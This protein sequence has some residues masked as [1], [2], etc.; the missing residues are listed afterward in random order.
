ML[1]LELNLHA[2][3]KRPV[4]KYTVPQKT[5]SN[6]HI[7]TG[8]SKREHATKICSCMFHTVPTHTESSEHC[9]KEEDRG[10]SFGAFQPTKGLRITL[11]FTVTQQV[12]HFHGRHMA[13]WSS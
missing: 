9:G 3:P 13:W 11:H 7:Q 8:V 10:I 1:C 6:I 2:D 12:D 4:C 5:Y